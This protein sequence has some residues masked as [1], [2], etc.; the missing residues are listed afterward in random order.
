MDGFKDSTKTRYTRG[1][2]AGVKGAA[3]A[4]SAMKAFKRGGIVET[5]S[6]PTDSRGRPISDEQLSTPARILAKS[7]QADPYETTPPAEA[8]AR[9]RVPRA[10]DTPAEVEA[11]PAK[12]ALD[13]KLGSL[14]SQR[15]EMPKRGPGG[16]GFNRT[17]Y[18]KGGLAALPRKK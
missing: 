16:A 2:P 15:G 3:C 11:V 6:R 18:A 9:R 14:P 12:D 10:S 1:G 8:P 13:L 7:G 5:S 4:A 17:P